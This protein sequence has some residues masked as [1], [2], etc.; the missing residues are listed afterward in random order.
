MDGALI[1]RRQRPAVLSM[2]NRPKNR[3]L[4][5]VASL[6]ETKNSADPREP[7]VT[8]D[9]ISA[10]WRI[11]F[12]T[13]QDA[14]LAARAC[15]RLLQFSDHEL[16]ER[17]SRLT[18]ERKSTARLLDEVA[19]EERVFLQHRL[20]TPRARRRMLGLPE[21]VVAC[22]FDLDG[23]LTPSATIHAAAWAETLDEFLSRRMEQTG[24]RFAPFKPF[25]PRNDYF[26]HIHGKPRLE[27]VHAFLASRGIRVAEGHPDDPADAETVYGLANRKNDALLRRLDREG[28]TAYAG[29]QQYL[30][31]AHEAG[32]RCAVVSSSGNTAA[33]LE[34]AG[35]DGLI[36]QCVDGNTIRSEQLRSK[37]EPDT[38]LAACRQLGVAPHQAAA[39][40][41]TL[42][43]VAAARAAGFKLVIGVDRRGR[44]EMLPPHG[45]DRVVTDLAALL[46]PV[47]AA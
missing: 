39:F 10:H 33:I 31:D 43:G 3:E 40:E 37:P 4:P 14:L 32:V 17:A 34:R 46:D 16:G 22:V 24:E 2:R 19:R 15:S 20:S 12:D 23:V 9:A 41:T 13:A 5:D 47:L 42:A 6:A 36:D 1:A 35:L 30:E 21:D 27:G 44:A 25:D 45:A 28:V 18:G 11:A 8:L 38:L 7:P 26:A 29:S